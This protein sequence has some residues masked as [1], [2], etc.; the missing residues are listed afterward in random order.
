MPHLPLMQWDFKDQL[1][2]TSRQVVNAGTPET[3]YYV[4]GGGGQRA[5]KITEGPNGS[6]KNERF[7]LSGFEIY[8][9]YS[10]GSAV[11][12][13]RETL[14]VMDDK[15]RIAL[16]ETQTFPNGVVVQSPLPAQRYQLANHLGSA[17]LEL[18][19]AGALI[20]YEEYSPY[21]S[22]TFQ[23]G[24][25]SGEVSL[26]R[27]RYTGMERDGENGFTYHGAR[28][29]APWLGRWVS[30]DP[31]GVK[32]ELNLFNY[33]DSNP[34]NRTDTRGLDW[35]VT[36][37]FWQW[38]PIRFTKEEVIPSAKVFSGNVVGTVHAIVGYETDRE[39]DPNQAAGYAWAQD[40]FNWH[41]FKAVQ[42]VRDDVVNNPLAAKIMG[43]TL[44][45]MSGFVP[46]APSG[47]D[48]P[49]S[50]QHAYKMMSFASKNATMVV[51]GVEALQS[52]GPT[53]P[54]PPAVAASTGY[55]VQTPPS[56]LTT[57]A[58]T[59]PMFAV[60]A[61]TSSSGGS[62]SSSSSNKT[63]SDKYLKEKFRNEQAKN[64]KK[65]SKDDPVR[66]ALLD[67]KTGKVRSG[68]GL[69]RNRGF[70]AG[71]ADARSSGLP[72]RFFL[73]DADANAI[74]GN[75]FESKGVFSG[76][77]GIEIR[78]GVYLETG[79]AMQMERMGELPFGTVYRAKPSLGWTP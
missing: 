40:K 65:L 60:A 29:Y 36:W 19:Q 11:V 7:Y 44:G 37:K 27:Y 4:Y 5:R 76:F 21:G 72:Q 14:Y 13:S 70:E 45:L 10:S 39:L 8:R 69:W 18:D 54:N 67:E 25:S 63:Y 12:L 64:L 68:R 53:P 57:P 78:P 79:T 2:A 52:T 46:G 33:C 49:E 16:I 42:S 51:S 62:N 30:A 55:P 34:L 6:K 31:I 32:D 28:Y 24:R 15:Q 75:V 48:L 17:C 20:S 35:E 1:G 56:V 9:E 50:M 47:D 41:K 58:G 71:H 61:T 23:A 22:P 26:K 74:G 3:T 77:T 59:L 73:Q 43:A 66:K 38:E